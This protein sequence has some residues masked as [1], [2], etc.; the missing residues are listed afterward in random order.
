[1]RHTSTPVALG[2][3]HTCNSECILC[4]HI[5]INAAAICGLVSPSGHSL[6]LKFR[7]SECNHRCTLRTM[8]T[9]LLMMFRENTYNQIFNTFPLELFLNLTNFNKQYSLKLELMNIFGK[10]KHA[11]KV[12]PSVKLRN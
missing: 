2:E 8:T 9:I 6:H 11:I 12:L 1:M 3:V 7:V 4:S 5:N 10:N